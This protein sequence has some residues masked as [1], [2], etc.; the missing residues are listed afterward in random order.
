MTAIV[1]VETL[2]CKQ[3]VGIQRVIEADYLSSTEDNRDKKN[4][5][6]VVSVS[7]YPLT[8]FQV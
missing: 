7:A 1:W 3:L 8:M 6:D 5:E 2:W 4:G